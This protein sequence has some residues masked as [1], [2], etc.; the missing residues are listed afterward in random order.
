MYVIRWEKMATYEFQ[1]NGEENY[2]LVRKGLFRSKK[3]DVSFSKNHHG[4]YVLSVEYRN[5]SA[6]SNMMSSIQAKR[7]VRLLEKL[8]V[9][10]TALRNTNFSKDADSRAAEHLCQIVASLEAAG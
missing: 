2:Q 7:I 9:S 6:D 10:K 3:L 8:G 4:R 5:E 1:Q